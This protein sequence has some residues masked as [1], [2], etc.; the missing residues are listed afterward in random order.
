MTNK[1]RRRFLRPSRG[2]LLR[3][4]CESALAALPPPPFLTLLVVWDFYGE[5]LA[6]LD[7][8]GSELAKAREAGTES[9]KGDLPK[10][11]CFL[12]LGDLS[13]ENHDLQVFKCYH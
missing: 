12:T 1:H 5:N 4:R 13:K 6:S 9:R 3:P 10:A 2:P 7:S 11:V 8:K